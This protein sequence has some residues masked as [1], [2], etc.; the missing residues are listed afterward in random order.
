VTEEDLKEI[1]K[2][3]KFM[4]KEDLVELDLQEKDYKLKLRRKE[5]RKPGP[6]ISLP[7]ESEPAVAPR[8]NGEKLIAGAV[9]VVAPL[10]GVFYRAPAPGADPFIT[11]DDEIRKG[12]T[13]CIIEAMK[14]MNEIQSEVSGKIIKIVAANGK[15]IDSGETLFLVMPS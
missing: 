10:G 15:R 7:A 11:E 12:Q 1:K 6:V 2:I 13:L 8:E 14:M 9:K 5:T 3:F 4:V